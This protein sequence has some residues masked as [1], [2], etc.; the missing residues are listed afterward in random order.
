MKRMLEPRADLCRGGLER[1]HR[2]LQRTALHRL[3]VSP[4][5]CHAPLHGIALHF[6]IAGDVTRRFI[7]KTPELLAFAK[8]GDRATKLPRYLYTILVSNSLSMPPTH[9][10]AH[11]S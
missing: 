8:R 9:W 6:F 4:L 11:A 10:S 2:I 5:G 7:D 3:D 1:D